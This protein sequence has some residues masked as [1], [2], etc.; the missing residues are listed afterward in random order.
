MGAVF[1]SFQVIYLHTVWLELMDFM[2]LAH[3]IS[4][5]HIKLCSTPTVH[6]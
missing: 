3:C 5:V 4:Y 2:N 6:G 1:K